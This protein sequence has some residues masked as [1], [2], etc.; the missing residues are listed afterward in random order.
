MRGTG[1]TVWRN[2]ATFQ[3]GLREQAGQGSGGRCLGERRLTGSPS[4]TMALCNDIDPLSYRRFEGF[5]PDAM[6]PQLTL[7]V[8]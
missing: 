4:P 1:A 8:A 7:D 6:M 3:R 2:S 5:A